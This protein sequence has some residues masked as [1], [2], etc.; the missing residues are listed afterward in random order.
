MA[1]NVLQNFYKTTISTA[2]AVGTGNRYVTALPT[3]TSGRLVINPSNDSKR[4]IVSYSAVGTDGGGNYVTLSAR[5]VGATTNQ[6]HA[7]GEPVRMNFTA[8]DYADIQTEL[9]ATLP[10]S[11][12]DTDPTMAA[13]SDTK[14]PSQKA[15]KTNLTNKAGLVDN[16]TFTG[17]NTFSGTTNVVDATT[18][19]NPVTLSQ[20][21]AAA[22]V[23]IQAG[24][25]DIDVSYGADDRVQSVHDNINGKTY[26]FEY[27]ANGYILAWY[28][29]VNRTVVSTKNTIINN[30]NN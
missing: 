28:D 18:S 11:Y 13:N 21:N 1:L 23:G 12:L 6:T 10:T 20:L 4:E 27:D 9:N 8:Q 19:S 25:E 29:G 15:V 3:P 24:F 7:V 16:N 22:L 14:I 26:V 5:G 17:T 30:I 2:W